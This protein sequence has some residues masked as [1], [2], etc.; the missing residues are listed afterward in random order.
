MSSSVVS[1]LPFK[2]NFVKNLVK[3][4][5][6]ER[7]TIN[8]KNLSFLKEQ[9]EGF[10][11][12]IYEAVKFSSHGLACILPYFILLIGNAAKS[13]GSDQIHFDYFEGNRCYFHFD[14][15]SIC[16]KKSKFD[17][18]FNDITIENIIS[19]PIW[20]T[21]SQNRLFVCL[22]VFEVSALLDVRH[23]P[24]LQ[25]CAISKKT[26]NA[27]LRKWQKPSFQIK[28]GRLEIFCGWVLP[29]LVRQCS[30]L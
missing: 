8:F 14:L 6:K 28:F 25:F 29:L 15:W 22:F 11:L 9:Q 13:I 27:T 2:L 4:I 19:S 20:T 7:D 21:E 30:E 10:P 5:F 23:C 1:K 16:V 24:K 12:V 3:C 17:W 18:A 26:N